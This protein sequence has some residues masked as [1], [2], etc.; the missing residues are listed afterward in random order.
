M[1]TVMP[2]ERFDV[3]VVGL[4]SA[5]EYHMARCCAE[6]L[7]REGGA[8]G[9]SVHIECTPLLEVEWSEFRAA[10]TREVGGEMWAFAEPVLVCLNGQVLGSHR[11]LVAWAS[12]ELGFADFRPLPLYVTLAASAYQ[13]EL[14]RRGHTYV[15]LDVSINA[16]PAGRL[17]LQLHRAEVPKTCENFRALC[18]GER[19]VSKHNAVEEYQLHYQNSVFHRIVP[20]GWI[21]GGD[22]WYGRGNGGESIYGATFEDENF[23]LKHDARGVLSMANRGR[24]SNGSQFFITLKPAP[25][26]D[27]KYVAFGR[28]VEGTKVLEAMEA[29]ECNNERPIHEIKVVECGELIP[30]LDGDLEAELQLLAD[31]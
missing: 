26:M 15:Y 23:A 30:Q 28:V 14:L 25:W 6:D 1:P 31:G 22:I 21:Q 24:H 19:G 16:Q 2:V 27:T 29:V 10:R 13:E 17:L 18:T 12:R 9:Q 4:V 5:V 3:S 20:D 7:L 11:E 8:S